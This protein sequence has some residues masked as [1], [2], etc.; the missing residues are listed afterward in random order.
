M[1]IKQEKSLQEVYEENKKEKKDEY[2]ER[3]FNGRRSSSPRLYFSHPDSGGMSKE[4]NRF[5]NRVVDLIATNRKE[6]LW[7]CDMVR[8]VR[9]RIRFVTLRKTLIALC[10]S[11]GKKMDRKHE[12]PL[13]EVSYNLIPVP[14]DRV[15]Y[16]FFNFRIYTGWAKSQFT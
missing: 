4:C 3:V 10:G 14:S 8:H 16:V 9:T 2:L 13:S 1:L 15:N 12:T 5:V 6:V 11:R 7:Y